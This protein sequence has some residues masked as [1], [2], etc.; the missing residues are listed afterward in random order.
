MNLFFYILLIFFSFLYLNKIFKKK[1]FL[2]SDTGDFHQRFTSQK[3]IPLTGGIF[4]L[5]SSIYYYDYKLSLF[6]FFGTSIFLLGFVSD[7]KILKSA[8]LRFFIQV[9]LV[10]L[11]VYLLDIKILD[12]RIFFLD[13]LLQN[14]ILNYLFVCF[15]I[16]ILINGSNFF[17][18]L[19][20]LNIGYFFIISLC[21]FYLN[22]NNEIILYNFPLVYLLFCLS[23]I[24][25]LNFFNKI[26]LGDSGSYLLGLFFSV[27]L[28]MI[29]KWNSNISPFFIILLLWYP[30]F[31]NLFSILRKNIF[32]K[33]PMSPDTKHLHQLI[34][35]FV[36]K[37]MRSKKIIYANVLSASLINFYNLLIFCL[38]IKFI[39][40]SQI[41]I[42]L[43]LFNI[44]VY[45]YIYFNL[46][47]L[48]YKINEK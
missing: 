8:K 9:L 42:V 40:N 46:F 36:K 39:Y 13:I 28:I 14:L 18:G 35:Y 5:I 25:A 20:T 6:Y 45:L 41:Q 4:L 38:S 24:Y 19:N 30:S 29:Y 47:I 21:I 2:I 31:E 22:L 27:F 11:F 17:D 1:N 26:F 12:T 44:I 15:C 34:F 43:I 16:L 7:L 3:K 48:K 23:I 10:Y 32:K 37:K 33:S